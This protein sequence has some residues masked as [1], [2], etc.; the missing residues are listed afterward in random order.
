VGDPQAFETFVEDNRRRLFG[1][2]CLVTGSRHEAE[3]IAQDAFLKV[4]ERW[5]RVSEVTTADARAFEEIAR[6]AGFSRILQYGVMYRAESPNR[7]SGS[8]SS[9]SI[10]SCPM[11]SSD[12]CHTSGRSPATAM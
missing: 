7:R 2:L 9:R 3:E 8:S 10:P 1:A 11:A 6:G 12:G 4:W 5:D